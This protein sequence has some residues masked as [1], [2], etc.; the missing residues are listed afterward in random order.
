MNMF[1]ETPGM[2]EDM[3][4]NLP[5]LQEVTEREMLGWEKELLGLYVTGRPADK[6]RE[7]LEA[8]NTWN[9]RELKENEGGMHDRPV[10]VA[11]EVVTMRKIL[12]QE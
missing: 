11:G 9:I 12:H 5:N 3:L 2:M 8:A 6:Y 10:A 1:G 7:A 4:G